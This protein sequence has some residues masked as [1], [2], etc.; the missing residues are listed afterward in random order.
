MHGPSQDDLVTGTEDGPLSS[1]VV[2]WSWIAVIHSMAV[3]SGVQS[4]GAPSWDLRDGVGFDP[5]VLVGGRDLHRCLG[6]CNLSGIDWGGNFIS[7]K[8][9]TE[10]DVE[11]K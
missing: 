10:L 3:F 7:R 6:I 5:L 11:D 8:S 9:A 1:S 4:W 2:L